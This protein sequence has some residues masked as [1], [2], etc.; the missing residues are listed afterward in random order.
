MPSSTLGKMVSLDG[1]MLFK[2]V[3]WLASYKVDQ[4]TRTLTSTESEHESVCGC[5]SQNHDVLP[6]TV[7]RCF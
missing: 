5:V 4:L 6:A 3:V 1:M 7:F 2:C